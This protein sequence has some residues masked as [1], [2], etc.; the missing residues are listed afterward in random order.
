M[1]FL[2]SDT[3]R[4]IQFLVDAKIT[5]ASGQK[6]SL[7]RLGLAVFQQLVLEWV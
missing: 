6:S 3:E 2:L 4:A 1:G 7:K 5:P